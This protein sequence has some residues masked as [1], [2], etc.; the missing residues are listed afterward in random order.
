MRQER[1]E[2]PKQ[3]KLEA[4]GKGVVEEGHDLW[5]S[6]PL[7]FAHPFGHPGSSSS[8]G[9]SADQ[10]QWCLPPMMPTYRFGIHIAKFG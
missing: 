4:K 1:R 8:T 9:F 3:A 10:M 7:H 5:I 2:H 6:Q